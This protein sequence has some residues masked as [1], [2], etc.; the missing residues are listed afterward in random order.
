MIKQ[1]TKYE[2][3]QNEGDDMGSEGNMVTAENNPDDENEHVEDLATLSAAAG[4]SRPNEGQQLACAL[5][6]NSSF[7]AVDLIEHLETSHAMVICEN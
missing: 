1:T 2:Q 3:T 5:C 7:S 6:G 4:S